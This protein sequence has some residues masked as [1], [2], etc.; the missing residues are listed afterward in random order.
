MVNSILPGWINMLGWAALA[1]WGAAILGAFEAVPAAAGAGRFL[2]KALGL[3]LALW[4]AVLIVGMAAGSREVLRPLAPF[5]GA[6]Q[7]MGMAN[8]GLSLDAAKRSEEHTSEL[9]S[10]MRI[11]YAVCCLK[12]QKY[13]SYQY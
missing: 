2:N 7:S 6:G 10:L 1:L 9:Q 5:V 4:A 11:S 3:L 8:A 13:T 12:K